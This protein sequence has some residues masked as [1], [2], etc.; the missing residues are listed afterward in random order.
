MVAKLLLQ[1]SE[2]TKLLSIHEGV[3]VEKSQ[4]HLKSHF[5]SN[6]ALHSLQE[7]RGI[8]TDLGDVAQMARMNRCLGC[9]MQPSGE[10]DRVAS[11]FTSTNCQCAA[12]LP[13]SPGRKGIPAA[14]ATGMPIRVLFATACTRCQEFCV[15]GLVQICMH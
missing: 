14:L 6:Y 9:S 3:G 8:S 2:R 12:G 7:N 13:T 15:T 10:F 11:T 4:D 5:F 1:R